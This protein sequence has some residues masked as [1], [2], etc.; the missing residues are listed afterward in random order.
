ML[1]RSFKTTTEM[2]KAKRID[3]SRKAATIATGAF[4][5]AHNASPYEAI[6]PPPPINPR[7]QLYRMWAATA[8]TPRCEIAQAKRRMGGSSAIHRV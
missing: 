7:H 2:I 8:P 4:V 6:E 3:D 5:I 1:E